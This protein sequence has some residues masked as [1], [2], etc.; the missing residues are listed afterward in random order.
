MFLQFGVVKIQNTLAGNKKYDF[1][2]DDYN[3]SK[4]Y[5]KYYYLKNGRRYIWE[6]LIKLKRYSYIYYEYL[7][8]NKSTVKNIYIKN[9]MWYYINNKMYTEEKKYEI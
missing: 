9:Q 2:Y 4:R 5:P 3:G 7:F 6:W 8:K 1:S